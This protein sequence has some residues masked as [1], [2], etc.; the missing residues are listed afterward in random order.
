MPR[1]ALAAACGRG[2]PW[3]AENTYA[4]PNGRRQCRACAALRLEAHATPAA[5][6][7][8]AYVP[9]PRG[10]IVVLAIPMPA[11]LRYGAHGGY[12]TAGVWGPEAELLAHTTT[13]R[14]GPEAMR[15]GVALARIVAARWAKE[16]AGA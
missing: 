14:P 7:N 1:K 3:D 13:P 4:A 10:R 5:D 12:C 15:E 8:G 9:S 11:D 2:H 16:D 6:P